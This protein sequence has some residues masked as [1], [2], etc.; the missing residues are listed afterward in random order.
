MRPLLAALCLVCLW[1][2]PLRAETLA[3]IHELAQHPRIQKYIYDKTAYGELYKL[4]K[5]QDKRLGLAQGCSGN[6]GVTIKGLI[7]LEPI[8][9]PEGA[10]HPVKGAWQYR[11]DLTRC[12][13]AKIY[14][15]V[16][17]AQKGGA[18]PVMRSY[19]PGNS[20][21]N[22]VLVRDAMVP[23]TAAAA[24]TAKPD[25]ACRKIDVLDMRVTQ[26]PESTG[27]KPWQEIWTFSFCGKQ[28]ATE[29]TF[30]PDA[31]GPG[32]TFHAKPADR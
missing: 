25:K 14:N 30:T 6:T 31:E 29:I 11:Y 8:D 27:R 19:F 10:A 13:E 3:S 7:L 24:M 21:A 32:T 12:G 9:F 23:A 4:G 28:G 22:L 20:R 15:A 17:V 1:T 18:A 16:A 5:E 2:A 26:E